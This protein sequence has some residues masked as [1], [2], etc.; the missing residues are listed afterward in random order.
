[1]GVRGSHPSS[2]RT[3]LSIT[4]CGWRE[5]ADA[6]GACSGWADVEFGFD[7]ASLNQTPFFVLVVIIRCLAAPIVLLPRDH[8]LAFSVSV[9][10]DP[11][12]CA[13]TD[14]SSEFSFVEFSTRS[15]RTATKPAAGRPMIRSLR[16]LYSALCPPPG[17]TQS[18]TQ[19]V[20][21]DTPRFHLG[22]SGQCAKH[23]EVEPH[24]E[25]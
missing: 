18:A 9:P 5:A 19:R 15:P 4:C 7:L 13:R 25:T 1:M 16:S 10:D 6:S 3:S 12:A 22:A 20:M 23:S 21:R 14:E 8:S 11:S 2:G 17:G 24:L